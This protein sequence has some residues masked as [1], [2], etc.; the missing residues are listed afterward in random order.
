MALSIDPMSD[1]AAYRQIADQLRARIGDGYLAL[2]T[3]FPVFL[4]RA[5]RPT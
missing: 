1:R 5:F 4:G 3:A 2:D